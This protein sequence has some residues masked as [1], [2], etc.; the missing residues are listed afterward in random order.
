[1]NVPV[2][3]GPGF[4]QILDV[5]RSDIVTYETGGRGRFTEEPAKGQWKE[6]VTQLHNELIELIAESTT[7]LLTKFFDQGGLSE[8]EFRSGIHAAIQRQLFIPFFCIS[9]ETGVG[10]ARLMDFIAK[11]GSSPVDREKVSRL[12]RRR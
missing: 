1:M 12:G 11:Y 4:N 9:A 6:R 10:V 3:P 2:N 5:L 7:T 8:E